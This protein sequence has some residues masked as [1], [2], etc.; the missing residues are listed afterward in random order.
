MVFR[1]QKVFRIDWKQVSVTLRGMLAALGKCKDMVHI[2]LHPS[3][4]RI[5]A[6]RLNPLWSRGDFIQ[7]VHRVQENGAADLWRLE[8][9]VF[10]AGGQEGCDAMRIGWLGVPQQPTL[11]G[12]WRFGV[13][14]TSSDSYLP[15]ST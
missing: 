15:M 2:R 1:R 9:R 10:M 12:E 8:L 3:S 4:P 5:P 7:M 13:R 6:N 11:K 14:G